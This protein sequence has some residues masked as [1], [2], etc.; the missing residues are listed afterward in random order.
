MPFSSQ[1]AEG[2]RGL[3]R[4]VVAGFKLAVFRRVGADD[5]D[6]SWGQVVALMALDLAVML[7]SDV[8][9]VGLSGQF[10]IYGFPGA[11]FFVPLV[12]VAAW[13]LCALARRAESALALMVMLLA[14]DVAITV[15]YSVYNVGYRSVPRVSRLLGGAGF[16]VQYAA[17]GWLA[18]ASAAAAVRT[19]SMR[20]VLWLPALA[21]TVIVIGLP[22][23]AS[24]RGSLW[25][26]RYDRR[27]YDRYQALA[28]E[29]AYYQQPRLLERELSG[30]KPGRKGVIDLY[31]IGVAGYASQDVFMREVNS[32]DKLFRERFGAEGHTVRLINNAK[33]VANTPIASV[34]ALRSAL[35]RVA[36]VMDRDEDIVFLFLTSHGSEDHHF[37]LEFWPLRFK[38]LDPATLRK[39]LDESGIKRRVVVVSACY[40]GGFVEALKDANTLVITASAPDRNSFGCSNEADFTYFG[41]AYFDEALRQT[42]SFVGAFEKAKPVIAEREKQQD[43]KGSEPQ[44]AVGEE[45][46]GPLAQL[47]QQLATG[48]PPPRVAAAAP[49]KY[50]EYVDLWIRPDFISLLR[51]ECV[52]GMSLG[53][54][55]YYVRKNPNYFGGLTERSPQWPRV[56]AAYAKYSEDYCSA[57]TSR[58][59]F[60]QSYLESAT[61]GITETDLDQLMK[62]L[63]TELGQ[64]FVSESNA[65]A[66]YTTRRVGELSKPVIDG[67]VERYTTDITKIRE[68]FERAQAAGGRR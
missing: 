14:L 44:I 31:L 19:L 59:Y 21:V 68:D 58:T 7:A 36:E 30:L 20:W 3:R 41:K 50:E 46:A 8:A 2:L 23:V 48:A 62:F 49:S 16:Y 9:N 29:E 13:A 12:L 40:S 28:G 61:R 64:R 55:E 52:R 26:P 42:Y 18:L 45:I 15:V 53:S 33:T 6:A 34:T 66:V 4:N 17:Y 32:V 1:L 27:D 11:I 37:S 57:A 39:L 22:E 67:V 54:P 35:A 63:R 5:V 38:T 60:R 24:Y 10:S 51:E 25:V 65:E 47:E 56:M 43:Y